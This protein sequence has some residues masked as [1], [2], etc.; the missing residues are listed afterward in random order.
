MLCMRISAGSNSS[1]NA[2]PAGSYFGSNQL[3]S[4]SELFK[5]PAPYTGAR[6]QPTSLLACRWCASL[7]RLVATKQIGQ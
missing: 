7:V 5:L 2:L 6:T 1:V 4:L 3:N